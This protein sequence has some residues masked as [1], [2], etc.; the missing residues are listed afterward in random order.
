MAI[1]ETFVRRYLEKSL[2]I[3]LCLNGKIDL[4]LP[5][6][7]LM[8]ERSTHTGNYDQGLFYQ[9]SYT[10]E[11]SSKRFFKSKNSVSSPRISE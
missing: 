1:N 11:I 2:K 10:S 4:L 5:I 9:S 8:F 3:G 7:S 6:T